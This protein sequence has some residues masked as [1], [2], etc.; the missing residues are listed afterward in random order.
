MNKLIG[1][2]VPPGPRLAVSKFSVTHTF[3]NDPPPEVLA[4]L[5]ATNVRSSVVRAGPAAVTIWTCTDRRADSTINPWAS[6]VLASAL[7]LVSD[8]DPDD[9]VAHPALRCRGTVALTGRC[10]FSGE[11]APLRYIG[12]VA[13]A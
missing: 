2:L 11:L 9:V 12:T 10:L 5:D 3:R 6:M 8:L 13:S 4:A 1:L 7:N